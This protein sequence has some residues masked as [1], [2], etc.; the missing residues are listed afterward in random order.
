MKKKVGERVAKEC[1]YIEACD[2]CGKEFEKDKDGYYLKIE[3]DYHWISRYGTDEWGSQAEF[4]SAECLRK[5]V[6]E[7][8]RDQHSEL[9]AIPEDEWI[10][11]TFS[12]RYLEELLG[13]DVK[14]PEA[15]TSET[16]DIP[17]AP[18]SPST[19]DD[20]PVGTHGG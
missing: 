3:L 6:E 15:P 16:A 18:S 14:R 11:L 7:D 19:A 8:L 12:R 5:F 9:R 13:I 1:V 20:L 10:S 17:P 4:C 2:H